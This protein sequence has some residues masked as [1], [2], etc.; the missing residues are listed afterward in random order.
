MD[1]FISVAAVLL[2]VAGLAGCFVPVL[3]GPPVSYVALLV[4]SVASY[5]GFSWRFLTVWFVVAAAVTA[6]DYFL[7]AVLARRFGGSRYAAAGTVAG[8]VAGL[9]VFPPWGVIAGPFLGALAGEWLWNRSSGDRALRVAAGAFAAFLLGTG[10]K[11]AVSAA[12]LY[13]VVA[14]MFV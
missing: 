1:I 6:A 3:P 11:A 10:A 7:P 4:S 2:A 9:F 5:S 12:I 8:M 13:Y 14:A